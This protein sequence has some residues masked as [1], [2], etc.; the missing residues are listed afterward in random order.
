MKFGG[1]GHQAHQVDFEHGAKAVHLKFAAPVD[2]RAL[3]QY[4]YIELRQRRIELL[5]RTGIA[6]IE[7]EI[8]EPFQARAFFRRIIRSLGPRAADGDARALDAEG[9]RDAVADAGGAADHQ[10]LLA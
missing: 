5:D 7:L 6:D 3:R 4:Q 8:V 2:H 10:H 9:L 1:A